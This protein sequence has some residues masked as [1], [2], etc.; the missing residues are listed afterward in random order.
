MLRLLEDGGERERRIA[1]GLE[2]AGRFT[3]ERFAERLLSVYQ[4]VAEGD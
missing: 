2:H 1:L 3:G 4:Q